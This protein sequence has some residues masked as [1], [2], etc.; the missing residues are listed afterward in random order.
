[1]PIAVATEVSTRRRAPWPDVRAGT[2]PA[3]P[4]LAPARAAMSWRH[5]VDAAVVRL[6]RAARQACRRW[7]LT[8]TGL[9]TGGSV[10]L[11]LQARDGAGRR[12][13]LKAG[14]PHDVAGEVAALRLLPAGPWPHVRAA[15]PQ[16]GL[17]LTSWM[18]HRCRA[19]QLPDPAAQIRVAVAALDRFM[20]GAC[21]V[22]AA[23][24]GLRA[25]DWWL[26]MVLSGLPPHVASRAAATHRRAVAA[27]PTLAMLH[28]DLIPKNVLVSAGARLAGVIDPKGRLGAPAV[29]YAQLAAWLVRRREF[30]LDAA[31]ATAAVATA[32]TR[33][34]PPG[35]DDWLT[36]A[37]LR[38]AHTDPDG[39]ASTR[40]QACRRL[41]G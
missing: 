4:D 11:V 35:F 7:T 15:D 23:S 8:P 16:A 1:M 2:P 32:S 36:L 30:G 18:E 21:A 12:V 20:T 9:L 17:L 22:P 31:G 37:L 33:P 34:L 41:A 10:G 25:A 24:A 39:G 27:D 5:D 29:A 38:E 14:D 19:D 26:D 28:G 6:A 40:H 13:V 3:L